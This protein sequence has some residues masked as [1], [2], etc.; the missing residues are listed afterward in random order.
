MVRS[1]ATPTGSVVFYDGGTLLQ[2]ISLDSNGVAVYAVTFSTAGAHV[3]SA[4]YPANASFA[5]STSSL[6]ITVTAGAA[7]N[8]TSTSL[9]AAVSS[10]VARGFIFTAKVAARSGDPIGNVIILDGSSHLGEVPLDET[11]TA[12]YQSSS[13]S[14][15]LHYISAFYSGSS[16]LAPSVSAVLTESMP[17][18]APDFS[19]TSSLS[20]GVVLEGVSTSAQVDVH[21]LNGFSE[22]VVLSCSTGTP[23]LSC[24]LQ[25]PDVVGGAGTSRLTIALTAAQGAPSTLIAR[26]VGRF[27]G[28]LAAPVWCLAFVRRRRRLG[29][30]LLMT[31]LSVALVV[32]CGSPASPVREVPRSVY[33]VTVTGRS[34][35]SAVAAVIH[36]VAIPVQVASN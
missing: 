20:H 35:Q 36:T 10:Q 30:L 7:S 31:L 3:V 11:G 27:L 15:G 32:G 23:R 26:S 16:T 9:S 13:L 14:P 4:T 34:Q 22:D 25:S 12:T 17:E 8:A 24:S 6:S 21:S 18:D 5:A 1:T 29:V 28:V 19:L 2:N 33:G